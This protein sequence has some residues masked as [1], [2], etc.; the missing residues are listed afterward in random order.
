MHLD[1]AKAI[2][3]KKMRVRFFPKVTGSVKVYG[4]DAEIEPFSQHLP[5]MFMPLG[6]YSYSQ[7]FFGST[8]RVG[9][10]CSI[11]KGVEV[12]G[13]AHPTNWIST[14]PA[15]YRRRPS[16]LN[17]SAREF[18]P[19]FDDISGKVEV[20]DDVWIGDDAL[21]AHGVK[22]GTGSIIA[23]RAV[24]TRDVPPY[25]I[26]AG[27]PARLIRF[28]FEEPV[29]YRLLQSKWWLWP[30]KCWDSADPRDV[31]HFLDLV[32]TVTATSEPMIEKR[33]KVKDLVRQIQ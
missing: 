9:R 23:A 33:V 12:M 29:I 2:K 16:K 24:V 25:A 3:L 7:S 32:D 22:L 18:F 19:K 10:Y 28:R 26:V 14:S 31:S 11:G 21:L 13:N 1:E 5:G 6:S 4:L 27:T 30:L 20:G 15:F 17:E 8:V